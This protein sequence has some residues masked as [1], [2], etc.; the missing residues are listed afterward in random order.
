MDTKSILYHNK[1]LRIFFILIFSW[2]LITMTSS[3]RKALLYQDFVQAESTGDIPMAMRSLAKLEREYPQKIQFS[4]QRE[5]F[6]RILNQKTTEQE[7]IHW[8][9]IEPYSHT[10]WEDF[11]YK[12][13][14]GMATEEDIYRMHKSLERFSQ[15]TSPQAKRIWNAKIFSW[16]QAQP[17]T[18]LSPI[19]RNLRERCAYTLLQSSEKEYRTPLL[20]MAYSMPAIQPEI[21]SAFLKYYGQDQDFANLSPKTQKEVG[22]FFLFVFQNTPQDSAQWCSFLQNIF[23]RLSQETEKI[24]I[25][26]LVASNPNLDIKKQAMDS[27][28]YW[29]ES[30]I[31]E[32]ASILESFCHESDPEIRY[33]AIEIALSCH[34]IQQL[35]FLPDILA[36]SFA[37]AQISIQQQAVA[38]AG[39]LSYFH[40]VAWEILEK[41]VQHIHPPLRQTAASSLE[42]FSQQTVPP[43]H[44]NSFS[45]RITTMLFALAQD[46]SPE[47]KSAAIKA[48]GNSNIIFS[49]EAQERFFALTLH[50]IS[51]PHI[52]LACV[53]VLAKFFVGKNPSDPSKSLLSQRTAK[54][55]Y[56]WVW[57]YKRTLYRLQAPIPISCKRFNQIHPTQVQ[58]QEAWQKLEILADSHSPTIRREVLWTLWQFAYELSPDKQEK[59]WQFVR[60]ATEDTDKLV[61]LAGF[62][63][64]NEI[65][66]YSPKEWQST[67]WQ[68][69][70]RLITNIQYSE[71]NRMI[72]WCLRLILEENHGKFSTQ[73][74]SLVILANEKKQYE[75]QKALVDL[76]GRILYKDLGEYEEEIW[77][78]LA[79]SLQ[80]TTISFF[81]T[82]MYATGMLL[83]QIPIGSPCQSR[84]WEILYSIE[85]DRK[86]FIDENLSWITEYKSWP[87]N[88]EEQKKI[89]LFLHECFCASAHANKAPIQ[90]HISPYARISLPCLQVVL[91]QSYPYPIAK[92]FGSSF[93]GACLHPVVDFL[94]RYHPFTALVPG[95]CILN[96]A[97]YPNQPWES[98]FLFCCFHADEEEQKKII[99]NLLHL[100][101]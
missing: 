37:S 25:A 17:E 63:I 100:K 10:I 86:K 53:P 35:S 50:A 28:Q 97:V 11:K 83:I 52:C 93:T 13:P 20:D 66:P 30:C 1:L 23:P 99:A 68:I 67:S 54:T 55:N 82:G 5:L 49:P 88:P 47:V 15:G 2:P 65:F 69:L 80:N 45:S 95:S 101:E 72:L 59:F 91:S 74:A 12:F 44:Q 85:K 34:K 24:K 77:Q 42:V 38:A 89:F 36:F 78:I 81:Q 98:F 87:K 56:H 16:F 9:I 7:Q 75:I 76:L 70:S 58:S 39:H 48:L 84:V 19:A 18:Y 29:F 21:C 22:E 27:F 32:K 43:S 61:Q 60:K 73:I 51:D 79:K 46:T 3:I 40:A 33:K 92:H 96:V 4:R 26:R 71:V 64:M 14:Q 8:N 90:M 57:E 6:Y 62:W 41:S 31:L 94:R